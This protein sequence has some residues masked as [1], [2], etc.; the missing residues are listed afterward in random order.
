MVWKEGDIFVAKFVGLELA[1]QGKNKKEAL[2]NL[3]EALDLIDSG[4]FSDGDKGLF[5]PITDALRES[6]P[7]M[8][9]ADFQSYAD[10]RHKAGELY[11][12]QAAWT[13]ASIQTVSRIGRFSSDQSVKEY[14][15]KIW[16]IEPD[17]V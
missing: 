16:K 17:K 13:K 8:V 7:H 1:S 2:K 14:A 15:Q 9:V 3:K 5:R 12:D 4:L 10:C 6:D 11:K